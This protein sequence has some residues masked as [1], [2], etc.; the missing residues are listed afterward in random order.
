MY[1]GYG[2]DSDDKCLRL[3]FK[4]PE[5][6][7]EKQIRLKREEVSKQYRLKQYESLKKE[8]ASELF[9]N[10]DKEFL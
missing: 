8:F 1:I 2:D 9:L 5:N 3:C 10:K 6:D 4:R 7:K